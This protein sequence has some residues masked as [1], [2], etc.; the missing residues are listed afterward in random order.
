M[1]KKAMKARSCADQFAAL[2]EVPKDFDPED[3]NGHQTDSEGEEQAGK[4]DEAR[5]H[6][7]PV[8]KSKLRKQPEAVTLGQEYSG[9]RISR[10]A[11]DGSE[12][13]EFETFN[14]LR[15]DEASEEEDEDLHDDSQDSDDVDERH[16]FDDDDS[17][18][19]VGSDDSDDTSG[20]EFS[21]EDAVPPRPSK[22]ESN[23]IDRAELRK[24][25]VQDQQSVATTLTEGA[26]ADSEKGKAVRA[27]RRAFDTL[28]NTR[29]KLQKALVVANSLSAIDIDDDDVRQ[30]T[31][32]V[33]A[34]EDAALKLWNNI[35]SL[36]TSLQSSRTGSKRSHSEYTA[37]YPLST[38]WE[39]TER[40]ENSQAQH[41][42]SILNFWSTKCR[43][44]G[45]AAATQ[46]Q[47]RLNQSVQ[48]QQLSDVLTG[49]LSD[50]SRLVSKTR[51]ARSC[52]PIQ[53]AA[54]SRNAKAV[55]EK[56]DALPI[57]DDADF[58]ST[59]LHGLISQR[60]SEAT[61]SLGNLNLSMNM[62]P[63]EAARQAKVK[64][65]VDTKASKGRKLRYNVHEQI[66]NFMAPEDRGA[67]GE[68]QAED[69]F[70]ALFGRKEVLGE[71]KDG[72]E[73][74]EMD[75]L[76]NP[77]DGLKLFAGA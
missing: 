6:Y 7:E 13:D 4:D 27:Q 75:D 19:N 62:Q 50:I 49:Q 3:G 23:P 51:L 18:E 55:E 66:Q 64:K 11:L 26:K 15:D 46:S 35:N 8:G 33:S 25:M 29:I 63:W 17:D 60:S 71:V 59:L 34:A 57:Y 5:A 20:T 24:L 70:G 54:T 40:Y 73:D 28:L 31:D 61:T 22:S 36:R 58:Y 68:S 45:S 47:N 10:D 74:E 43:A 2:Y 53:A 30:S 1:S 14:N 42:N 44:T 67:W 69:L 76:G 41:R 12:E 72:F 21:D 48:G 65:V 32:V 9:A 37:E 52:A 38:L 77:G 39:D 56:E 16:G